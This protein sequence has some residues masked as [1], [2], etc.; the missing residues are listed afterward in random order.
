MAAKKKFKH[1]RPKL[2][3]LCR[4]IQSGGGLGDTVYVVEFVDEVVPTRC[5][6]RE[7][8]KALAGAQ[9]FDLSLLQMVPR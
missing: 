3:D 8:G 4:V 7:A 9:A 6:I 5:L 1:V 2:G